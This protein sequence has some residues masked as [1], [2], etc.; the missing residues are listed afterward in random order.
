M[1]RLFWFGVGVYAGVQLTRRGR[2]EWEA[3]KNDP[4]RELDRFV[5][6]AT[7]LAKR[8]VRM[9]RTTIEV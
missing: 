5:R 6:T 3:V 7:P 2:N 1:K 8:F 9:V 4:M